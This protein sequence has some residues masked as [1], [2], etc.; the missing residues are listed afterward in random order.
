MRR[1]PTE[2]ENR[3]LNKVLRFDKR[4]TSTPPASSKD[5]QRIAELAKLSPLAYDRCRKA[6][7]EHLGVRPG[8]LDRAVKTERG[9]KPKPAAPEIDPEELQHTAGHIIKHPDIL[10]L[11]AKEFSKVVAGEAINGKLLYLVATSRL[12]DKP[13]S[14]AVKGTSAGG[15]SEIRKRVLEFFPPED[16]VSFTSLS[17]KA[18]LYYD[19]DFS[20][21]ILSMG[22]AS[23]TEE[24]KFQDYLLR[25]LISEGR[26]RYPVP[27]KVG[28][29]IRTVVIEKEGPVTFLVTTTKGKLDPENETRLLS[30]E[31]DDTREQTEK[32]LNKVALVEGLHNA[33]SAD[34]KS[35]QDFQ[36]W[37]AAGER[38]VI[39]P[40]AV[41][42]AGKIEAEA[43]RLRRDFGQVLRAIKT[44][45]LLHRE[46][47]DRDDAGRVVANID[48]D[49]ETVRKL[50]NAIVSQGSGVAV[51]SAMTGTIEAVAKATAGMPKEEG[52]DAKVIAKLLKLD[53]SAT[54]RRLSV[55]RGDGYI[56]N[57]EQRRGMPGKYRVSAGQEVELIEILPKAEKLAQRA[58]T[59]PESVQPCN[60]EELTDTVLGDNACK[61]A[62][63]PVVECKDGAH[64]CT[65][66]ATDLARVNPLGGNGKSL[67]VARLHDFQGGGDACVD[68]FPDIPASLDRRGQ[69]CAHCGQ[70]WGGEPWDYDGVEVRLH[71][72]CEE[73]WLDGER[74]KGGLQ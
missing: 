19:G 66:V 24:Q 11:F 69:V 15:K 33:G 26:L 70:P 32:V 44:H 61:T 55:A 46:H 74:Q 39:V 68:P 45:A 59:P 25:E 13:M 52:A 73:A 41:A 12:F 43:V 35:W 48:D 20:H 30:L 63:K 64:A 51:N 8:A 18:L 71:P 62:C 65:P 3:I 4:D 29:E 60:R 34:V 17:D 6:E 40:F 36:R 2:D 9:K 5:E 37:L 56:V 14:A 23:A 57:M 67:P 47:R 10:S 58:H 38:R 72:Q 31:M 7:A 28:N 1:E 22:E 27:Q 42:L 21:K 16:V 54:W 53:R 50:M 49:Y